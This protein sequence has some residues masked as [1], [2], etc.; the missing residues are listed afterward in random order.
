MTTSQHVAITDQFIGRLIGSTDAGGADK[1]THVTFADAS[2]REAPAYA[3]TLECDPDG[4]LNELP[5]YF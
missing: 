1:S 2:L 3:K 5:A 4:S